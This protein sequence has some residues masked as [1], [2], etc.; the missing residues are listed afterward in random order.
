MKKVMTGE[1][2][3]SD[4]SPER[5]LEAARHYDAAA[6]WLE[7]YGDIGNRDAAVAFNRWRAR[8]FAGDTPHPPPKLL[9]D[10]IRDHWRK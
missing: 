7:K 3:L 8:Y 5:Q 4:L 2:P 9:A 6:D 1:R 10:F